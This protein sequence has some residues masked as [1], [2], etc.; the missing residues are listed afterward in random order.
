MATDDT[1]TSTTLYMPVL[2]PPTPAPSPGPSISAALPI[3]P[4]TGQIRREFAI[5]S[6]QDRRKFLSTLITDCTAEELVYI[7]TTISNIL[8]RDFL[9]DLP[10]ELA[11]YILSFIDEPKSLCTAACVS[12]YW[13]QLVKDE[14]LWKRL[15]SVHRFEPEPHILRDRLDGPNSTST[16]T[17]NYRRHFRTEYITGEHIHS[18]C[19]FSLAFPLIY[20]LYSFTSRMLYV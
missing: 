10:F 20:W 19:L 1:H 13:A 11:V 14:W 16:S 15:C 7:S 8:R 9:R 17:F 2:S 18:F 12:K 4:L 5:M 6:H 3:A